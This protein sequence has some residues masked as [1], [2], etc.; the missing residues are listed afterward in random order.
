MEAEVLYYY[1]NIS[2]LHAI[3]DTPAQIWPQ[4]R[5]GKLRVE[6]EAFATLGITTRAQ[7]PPHQ[8]LEDFC[9]LPPTVIGQ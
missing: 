4:G 7:E 2:A 5:K 3:R 8:P 6:K 1:F 9:V